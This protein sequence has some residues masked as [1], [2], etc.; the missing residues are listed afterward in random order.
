M[1]KSS[2]AKLRSEKKEVVPG[3]ARAEFHQLG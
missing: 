1:L 2:R 3:D